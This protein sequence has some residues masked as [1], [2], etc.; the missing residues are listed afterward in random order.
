MEYRRFGNR[1]IVRI[2]RGEEVMEQLACVVEEE[3]IRLGSVSGIGACDYL[4]CGVYDTDSKKY[5]LHK[6][7]GPMEITSLN[8][9]ITVMNDMPYL[10]LH[11]NICDEEQK[12]YGGHLNLCKISGTCELFIDV[13]DGSVDRELDPRTGTGLNVFRF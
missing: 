2:E 4:E 7:T 12:A 9:N 10:H 1:V 3:K 5:H 6:M 8:G 11:I 13:L